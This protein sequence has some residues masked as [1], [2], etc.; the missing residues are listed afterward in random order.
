[1]RSQ[2]SWLSVPNITFVRYSDKIGDFELVKQE[3]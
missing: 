1:M 3:M 2:I